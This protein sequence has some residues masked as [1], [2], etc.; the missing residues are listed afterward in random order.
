MLE[1][2]RKLNSFYKGSWYGE[3]VTIYCMLGKVEVKV[4]F[5]YV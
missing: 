1:E 2:P 3:D 5:N 4:D